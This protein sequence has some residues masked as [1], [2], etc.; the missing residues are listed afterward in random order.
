MSNSFTTMGVDGCPAGWFGVT[1]GE[2]NAWHIAIA[3]EDKQLLAMISRKQLV[4]ID[5]PLGLLESGVP[6]RICDQQARRLLGRPRAASVFPVPGRPAVYAKSYRDAQTIN[7]QRIGSGLSQQA[8][9]IAPKIRQL[10]EILQASPVLRDK[11]RES[12]PEICFWSLNGKHAMCYNKKHSQGFAERYK[13]LQK[14]CTAT[15]EIVETALAQ[16]SRKKLARDDILD[17]LVLAVSAKYGA[18]TLKTIPAQPPLDACGIRME[19][20]YADPSSLL[21]R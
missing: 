7:R 14:Y 15:D 10:D 5:M 6:Q 4:L 13:L 19:M 20:V 2:G 12:H 21:Q 8:W 17:A 18:D 11:L 1:L 3:E 16:Y 9:N